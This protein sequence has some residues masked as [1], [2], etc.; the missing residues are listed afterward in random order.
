MQIK[1]LNKDQSKTRR[2]R[3]AGRCATEH[4]EKHLNK[5]QSKTRRLR[6]AGR[7]A[8]EHADKTPA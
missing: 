5:D 7:Y 4:E 2:L 3:A 8:T 1:H 6:A